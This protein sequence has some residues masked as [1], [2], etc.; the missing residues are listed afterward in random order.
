MENQEQPRVFVERRRKKDWV[1]T[2]IPYLSVAAWII[3]AVALVLLDQ[4]SPQGESF[5]SRMLGAPVRS[6]WNTSMLYTAFIA[7]ASSFV[8]CLIGFLFNL[9]RHSRKTDRFNKSVIILGACSLVGL[10]AFFIRFSSYL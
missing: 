8:I 6:S 7:L 9:L 5:F 3:A 2:V 10:V 4:A 1:T